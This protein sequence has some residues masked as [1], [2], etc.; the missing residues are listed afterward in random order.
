[1]ILIL[2]G[3]SGAGKSTVGKMLA[4]RLD[5]KFYDTDLFHSKENIEKMSKGVP[6]SD[7]DREPWLLS[8]RNLIE[9][10]MLSLHA[11]RLNRLI[12]MY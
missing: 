2:M 1:M 3:V 5:C 9:T 7:T 4:N 11:L 8:I 6:L 12:E 10:K